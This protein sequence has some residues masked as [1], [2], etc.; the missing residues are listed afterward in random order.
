M[1]TR[2]WI[3][4]SLEEILAGKRK[5][6]MENKTSVIDKYKAEPDKIWYDIQ[7]KIYF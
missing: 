5:N 3:N 2:L 1:Q 4:K 6:I 7:N